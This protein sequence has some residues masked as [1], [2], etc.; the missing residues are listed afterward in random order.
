MWYSILITVL[1]GYLLG[2][3]NGAVC[4]SQLVAHEDVRTHGS[5]N[6]G[7]TNFIRNY[8][9]GKSIAVILIDGGKAVV[10]C[11]AGGLIMSA[12]D[13]DLYLEGTVIGGL[14]LMLGHDF[15]ALLGFKGGKGIMSGCLIAF[16]VDWRVGLLILGVFAIAYFI[17]WY[18]SLGSVLASIAFGVGF[19]IFHHDNLVVMICGVVMGVLA[20]FMHRSNIVRLLKGQEKKTNLFGKG[21]KA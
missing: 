5:G 12:V 10:A 19:V 14:A 8:G 9:A 4:M 6:A 15:P 7:L 1:V 11:L 20:I 3:L 13:P 17:T 2:N 21:K 16:I 18:V